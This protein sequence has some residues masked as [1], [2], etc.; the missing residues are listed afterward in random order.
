MIMTPNTNDKAVEPVVLDLMRDGITSAEKM[1]AAFA[2]GVGVKECLKALG[3]RI[4]KAGKHNMNASYI[5]QA[6]LICI[7]NGSTPNTYIDLFALM[8]VGMK[9]ADVVM[10]EVYGKLTGIPCDVHMIRMFNAIGWADGKGDDVPLQLM[11]WLP[12][13]WWLGLNKTFAGMGQLLQSNGDDKAKFIALLEEDAPE[14]WMW[15]Q[16]QEI[17]DL[18]EYTSSKRM[19]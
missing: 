13:Y 6:S 14:E 10:N 19:R 2:R 8:G 4:K 7:M 5:V 18:D 17:L 1:M 15:D 11:S 16:V 3:H 12:K 9:I